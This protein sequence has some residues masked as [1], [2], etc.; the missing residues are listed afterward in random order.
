MYS[1]LFQKHRKVFASYAVFS[2]LM[3]VMCAVGVVAIV[4]D[5]ITWSLWG[6]YELNS[7]VN[8]R[9]LIAVAGVSWMAVCGVAAIIMLIKCNVSAV[10]MAAEQVDEEAKKVD[11][12]GVMDP[13]NTRPCWYVGI[14]VALLILVV[15]NIF[16]WRAVPVSKEGREAILEFVQECLPGKEM[17]ITKGSAHNY[18]LE[19]KG[20]TENSFQ[21]LSIE[22]MQNEDLL[23]QENFSLAVSFD[24]RY[25]NAQQMMDV[26]KDYINAID[27]SVFA[28][29]DISYVASELGKIE[30]QVI[31]R[32]ATMEEVEDYK[33]QVEFAREGEDTT[34]HLGVEDSLIESYEGTKYKKIDI[35]IHAINFRWDI[36]E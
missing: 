30:E 15:G 16:C 28:D 21:S 19:I 34:V 29:G 23:D 26:V 35:R 4:G 24:S 6:D 22:Y 36:G 9:M 7:S 20:S 31:A 11:W 3:K 18:S 13:V 32:L 17:E 5:F 27:S 33:E 14:G 25:Y 1:E 2:T 8:L 10:K 12:E